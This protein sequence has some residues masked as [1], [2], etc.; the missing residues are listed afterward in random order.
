[1]Q[2]NDLIHFPASSA[3]VVQWTCSSTRVHLNPAECM[4]LLIRPRSCRARRDTVTEG[5]SWPIP[6]ARLSLAVQKIGSQQRQIARYARCCNLN[7]CSERTSL[8]IKRRSSRPSF[9]RLLALAVLWPLIANA[10]DTAPPE[11]GT[12]SLLATVT[13]RNTGA[14]SLCIL[15]RAAMID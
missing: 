6:S 9:A 4:P 1:M 14:E 7:S 8:M 15:W 10:H 12:I 13:A 3:A 5:S 11:A 2:I